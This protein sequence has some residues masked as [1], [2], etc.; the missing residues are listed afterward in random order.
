MKLGIFAKIFPGN[1]PLEIF[2]A[3][4]TPGYAAVQYNMGGDA[5]VAAAVRDASQKTGIEIAAL[6]A[7]Y[8]MIHPQRAVREAGRRSFEAIAAAAGIVRTNLLTVC[9]GTRDPDDQWRHHPDNQTDAAWND[10]CD[11]CRRLIAIAERHGVYIGVEPEQGNVVNSARRAHD[12][13]EAMGSD[14]IRIVFDAA[15]LFVTDTPANR[16]AIIE[17]AVTLLKDRIAIAHAKD[18]AADG[19]FTTAGRGV[20]DYPHYLAALASAG[21]RGSLIAHHLSA[22]DAAP[23]AI[24]L[25][26]GLAP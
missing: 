3:V 2:E 26:N 23:V 9:T 14:R 10:M 15:N 5:Q 1:S 22:E 17:D 16:R 4:A 24:F 25:K 11:E 6:S 8:N 12:L 21:F 19:S 13:I 20:I 18:R 7:T